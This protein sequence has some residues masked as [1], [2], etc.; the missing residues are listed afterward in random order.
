MN[1]PNKYQSPINSLPVILAIC[2]AYLCF[3]NW[4][5]FYFVFSNGELMF[6]IDKPLRIMRT[7]LA[8][9]VIMIRT[10]PF[11]NGQTIESKGSVYLDFDVSSSEI[12]AI[13][14]GVN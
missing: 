5:V 11:N 2:L 1:K 8:D 4:S 10:I 6:G 13:V 9:D 12:N 3:W 14:D 7:V